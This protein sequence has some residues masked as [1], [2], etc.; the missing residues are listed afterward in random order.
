MN[1]GVTPDES[2]T[3]GG[4]ARVTGASVRSLRHYDAHGLLA[5]ARRSNGYRVFPSASV[6]RVRQIQRLLATGFNLAE[7]RAFPDCM[8]LVEGAGACPQTVG[9]QRK[10]LAQIERQI[11]DLER[12]RARLRAMLAEGQLPSPRSSSKAKA[13]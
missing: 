4:L 6:V 10:R 5:S 11:A 2:L 1:H 8:R 12:R 3:V 7:I 9:T 13:V